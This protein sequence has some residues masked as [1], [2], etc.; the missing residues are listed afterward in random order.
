MEP[1]GVT[2]RS[3]T[4][5]LLLPAE[6]A[7]NYKHNYGSRQL[8]NG[9]GNELQPLHAALFW[10]WSFCR[11]QSDTLPSAFGGT[12]AR[13]PER[14]VAKKKKKKSEKKFTEHIV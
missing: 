11:T 6:P 3:A 2:G 10:L 4:R 7:L 5:L 8:Y 12:R 1:I 14:I 13:A 9:G